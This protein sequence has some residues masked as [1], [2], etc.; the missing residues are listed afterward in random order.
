MTLLIDSDVGG[1]LPR[2]ADP[3]PEPSRPY[4]CL[5]CRQCD[6]SLP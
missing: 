6:Q 5:T 2:F 4:C 1:L 3:D